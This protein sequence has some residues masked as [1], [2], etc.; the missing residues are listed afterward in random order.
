MQMNLVV[1]GDEHISTLLEMVIRYF[2]DIPNNNIQ[3]RTYNIMLPFTNI[4][5]TMIVYKQKNNILFIYWQT[6]SLQAYPRHA[7]TK[8]ILHYL[9]HKGEGGIFEYLHSCNLVSMI[10]S[11]LKVHT[12]T[13]YMYSIQIILT[14][15]GMSKV[16]LVI[17]TVFDYIDKLK[18]MSD[19]EFYTQWRELIKVT[20]FKFDYAVAHNLRLSLG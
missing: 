14:D 4:M 16:F 7:I 19:E 18:T 3:Q 20:T 2:S 9:E 12:T 17:K 8:F 6:P 5:G 11:V 10:Y 1:F 15:E 13:F